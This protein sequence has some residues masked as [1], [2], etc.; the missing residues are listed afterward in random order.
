MKELNRSV[1]VLGAVLLGM[2]SIIGT[3]IFVSIGIAADIAGP[4]VLLA[5]CIAA[6]V[7]TANGLN[8]AQLAASHPVSGGSYEYGYKYLT[9]SLGFTAGWLFLLAKSASAATAAL[10]FAAYFMRA[11][12]L[13]GRWLQSAVAGTAVVLFTLLVLSGVR[14]SNWHNGILVLL[15]C[16][17]LG[18]FVLAGSSRV[19]GAAF[20]PFFGGGVPGLLEASALAFVAYTGYGRIAT[21]GEEVSHP[22]RNIPRAMIVTLALSAL[23]YAAVAFV[24]VGLGG[25]IVPAA[26]LSAASGYSRP[27]TWIVAQGAM[28]AMLG[29]LL[30][31]VLGLS[32]MWLAMGRR[33]DMP[34]VLARVNASGTTPVPAVILTGVVIAALVLIGDVKTTWSFSAFTVLVYYAITN[35]AALRLPPGQRMYPR[36]IALAGLAACLFLAF[37]VNWR[38]W[39][40]GLGLIAAGLLWHWI[41]RWIARRAH[42]HDATRNEQ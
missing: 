40:A 25:T 41:A 23:V 9:P 39:A 20:T 1:G 18:V 24:L 10:G 42:G 7:A 3:G 2:G 13:H 17:A 38:V 28:I 32:R 34:S 4:S 31:L 26:P 36:W 15:A 5:V 6:C 16:G 27:V 33:G 8:S 21:M 30:N 11:L 29:V 22:R 12:D 14:R 19:S 37:W 35:A